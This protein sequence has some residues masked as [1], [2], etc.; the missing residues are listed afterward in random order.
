MSSG[1]RASGIRLYSLGQ[2][3]ENQLAQLRSPTFLDQRFVLNDLVKDEFDICP[4][5]NPAVSI[6]KLQHRQFATDER[7]VQIEA[8]TLRLNS[9]GRLTCSAIRRPVRTLG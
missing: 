7:T 9:T 3:T 2:L 4:A 5:I 8:L 6:S 1:Y